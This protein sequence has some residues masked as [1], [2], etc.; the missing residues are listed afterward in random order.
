MT[1]AFAAISVEFSLSVL[2]AF[3]IRKVTGSLERP[4]LMKSMPVIEMLSPV[5]LNVSAIEICVFA[6]SSDV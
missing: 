2:P 4:R 1:T 3:L 6:F 5:P